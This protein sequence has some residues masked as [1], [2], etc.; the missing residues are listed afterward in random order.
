[1]PVLGVL[2]LQQ[3]VVLGFGVAVCGMPVAARAC[4]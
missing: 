1:V 3:A 4:W 2:A